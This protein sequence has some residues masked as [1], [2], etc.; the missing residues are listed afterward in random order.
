MLDQ[1][2]FLKPHNKIIY[3]HVIEFFPNHMEI[4]VQQCMEWCDSYTLPILVPLS[5]W[6]PDPQQTLVKTITCSEPIELIATTK[7]SQHLF[8]TTSGF[9]VLMYHIASGSQIR[10]L[11]GD[12][13]FHYFEYIFRADFCI[14]IILNI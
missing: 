9:K 5:S 11:E 3:L 2:W 12:C 8:C 4:L 7:N 1:Y 6:L 10:V 14:S 13:H